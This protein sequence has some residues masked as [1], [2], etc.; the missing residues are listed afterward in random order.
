MIVPINGQYGNMNAYE[1]CKLGEAIM[2][3]ILIPCHFWMFLEHVSDNG[4]GDPAAFVSEGSKL[5]DSICAMVM[6]PGEFFK[7]KKTPA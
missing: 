2:P 6:A 1:A 4:T 5:P 7:F 3:K